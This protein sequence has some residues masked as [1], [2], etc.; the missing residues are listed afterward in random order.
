VRVRSNF[1]VSLDVKE[2][3]RLVALCLIAWVVLAVAALAS[4]GTGDNHESRG[5]HGIVAR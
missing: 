2:T 5:T 1:N 3:M 4:G